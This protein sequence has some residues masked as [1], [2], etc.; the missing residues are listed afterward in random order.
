MVHQK[1]E[2]RRKQRTKT[3]HE[4]TFNNERGI[5]M[6]IK[7]L[8]QL[9]ILAFSAVAFAQE[10]G[11]YLDKKYSNLKHPKKASQIAF[12]NLPK[13]SDVLALVGKQSP[14]KSQGARGTCSIF[15]A[16]AMYESATIRLLG[17]PQ[18]I[19]L[20][21]EWLEYLIMRVQGSEGSS[22]S[23]NFSTLLTMSSP[24]EKVFPYIGETWEEADM[25]EGTLSYERCSGVEGF[26]LT[27]CLL[28]HNKPELLDMSDEEMLNQ[29]S[30]LYR[31]DFVQA[32]TEAARNLKIFN[33]KIK[34]AGSSWIGDTAKVKQLLISGEPVTLDIDFYYG[35]WNHRKADEKGVKRNMDHWYKGIVG[36]P[37]N[38][39]LDMKVSQEDPAGHSVVIVGYD[40]DVIVETEALMEDGSVQ[41]FTYKGVYYFKNSWGK[42]SFG[43]D[44]MIDGVAAPGYG[45]ITQKYA[46]SIG[47]FYRLPVMSK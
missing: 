41:K 11:A 1:C 23:R 9:V 43:K 6:K 33:S 27:A 4:I 20:S 18:D 40:D 34:K 32:R 16:T 35:A 15:S 26:T 8:G 2:K 47:A 7:I 13:K 36:H 3:L 46:E 38:G 21:E 45:M 22:S 14:V 10:D 17:A 25:F 29:Q 37:E 30:P 5:S 19:D 44:M 31:P 28:G 42:D 24:S 39:S 12:A